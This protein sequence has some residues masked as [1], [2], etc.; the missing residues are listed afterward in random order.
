MDGQV[1]F[2]GQAVN[3]ASDKPI[4]TILT[5]AVV[6]IVVIAGGIV[7][8]VRPESLSF[9]QYVSDIAIVGGALGLGAGIGRGIDSYGKQIAKPPDKQ[10]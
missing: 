6:L 5:V 3:L 4:V 8:I 10:Q 7:T 1:G 2:D 9:H